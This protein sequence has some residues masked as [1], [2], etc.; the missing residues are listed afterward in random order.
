MQCDDGLQ[1]MSYIQG[2]DTE[3]PSLELLSSGEAS[4]SGLRAM[5]SEREESMW[6]TASSWGCAVTC[7]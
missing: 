7:L 3:L 5:Q 4:S 2:D 6:A 1:G